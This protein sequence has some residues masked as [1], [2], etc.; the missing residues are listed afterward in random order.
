VKSTTRAVRRVVTNDGTGIVSHA[1]A[2]LLRELADD[3]GLTQGWTAALLDTYKRAPVH[4]P[5]RVLTD[6][7]GTLAD[8]GDCLADLAAL[9]E[10]AACSVRSLRTRPPIGSWT[11]S[12]PL[13]S[14]PCVLRE[15]TPGPGSGP[16]VA[17]RT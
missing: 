15:P 8:G 7:A 2:A 17:D 5:G 3:S 16:P 13:N 14:R 12:V 10:Q 1:G 9:R 11:G 4:L 6:L